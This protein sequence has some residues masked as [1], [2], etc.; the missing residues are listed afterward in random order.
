MRVAV[1]AVTTLPPTQCPA[2]YPA[3]GVQATGDHV[4]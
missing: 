2:G 1:S 4:V 3:R